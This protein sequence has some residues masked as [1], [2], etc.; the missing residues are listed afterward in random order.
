LQVG[1]D[2]LAEALKRIGWRVHERTTLIGQLERLR[3]ALLVQ[4]HLDFFECQRQAPAKH[5]AGGNHRRDQSHQVIFG[6]L[7]CQR[8]TILSLMQRVITVQNRIE[9]IGLQ[10]GGGRYRGACVVPRRQYVA[11]AGE[12]ADVKR[13]E[14]SDHRHS[15]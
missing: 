7:R 9:P 6:P 1:V 4:H 5:Q 14:G 13:R 12:L 15:W 11:V 8:A 2:Q 10:Q 3:Q